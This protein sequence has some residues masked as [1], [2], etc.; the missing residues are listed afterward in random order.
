MDECFRPVLFQPGCF[1]LN[2]IPLHS[3]LPSSVYQKRL[4][5][6]GKCFK[7]SHR[8][9]FFCT[10]KKTTNHRC[11]HKK[12]QQKKQQKQQKKLKYA[13]TDQTKKNPGASRVELIA[14]VGALQRLRR[15]A[16]G[17]SLF[18]TGRWIFREN[19]TTNWF[20]LGDWRNSLLFL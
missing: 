2:A 20:F 17:R 18:G 9:F 12:Q 15:G 16:G 14:A 4:L 3:T 1:L 13:E 11:R 19:E 7:C 8:F 5:C 6:T 10:Q